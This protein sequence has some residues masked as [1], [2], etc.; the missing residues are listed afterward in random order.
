M[1]HSCHRHLNHP[2]MRGRSELGKSKV[3]EEKVLRKWTPGKS[4]QMARGSARLMVF[5]HAQVQELIFDT[6]TD[7]NTLC[8]PHHGVQQRRGCTFN[9][10]ARFITLL[11]AYF[12]NKE[13]C[14]VA[15]DSECSSTFWLASKNVSSSTAGAK[16]YLKIC[17]F[18]D[19]IYTKVQTF[20]ALRTHIGMHDSADFAVHT[21][22][23]QLT[24]S[25]SQASLVP[26]PSRA[27]TRKRVWYIRCDFLVVLSQHVYVSCVIQPVS[28][29]PSTAVVL[30]HCARVEPVGIANRP[31]V[32]R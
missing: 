25:L 16:Y 12:V 15:K 19:I 3:L 11:S 28:P 4:L 1:Y 13:A 23:C 5:V 26:R 6:G 30:F 24:E 21:V 17:F 22:S 2:H 7:R 29:R 9:T 32:T 10:I 8:L 20:G 18:R 14:N 31:Y 27:P